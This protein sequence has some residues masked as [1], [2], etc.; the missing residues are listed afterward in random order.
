[1]AKSLLVVKPLPR[2]KLVDFCAQHQ[3]TI[4]IVE[5]VTMP[6]DS[7]RYIASLTY[8]ADQVRVFPTAKC[9]RSGN[10]R[11]ILET[12]SGPDMVSALTALLHL[13]NGRSFSIV[14]KISNPPYETYE[15]VAPVT[16]FYPIRD[17]YTVNG[18]YV[19]QSNTNI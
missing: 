5:T 18:E 14:T 19:I 1:M 13:I 9:E 17:V 4:N 10:L 2:V 6:G 3:L 12:A 16:C 7:T 8:G 11:V 15:Q